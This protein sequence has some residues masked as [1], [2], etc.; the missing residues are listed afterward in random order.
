[1]IAGKLTDGIY[2]KKSIASAKTSPWVAYSMKSPI[3]TFKFNKRRLVRKVMIHVLND[4]KQINIFQRAII[5]MGTQ[6]GNFTAITEYTSNIDQ[7]NNVGTMAVW[8]NLGEI[9]TRHIQIEFVKSSRWLLV[10]EVVFKSDEYPPKRLFP[11]PTVN[12]M[13]ME[14]VYQSVPDG[15]GEKNE[16][17]LIRNHVSNNMGGNYDVVFVLFY[18]FYFLLAKLKNVFLVFWVLKVK[19]S[20]PTES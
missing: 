11:V 6:D 7:L 18:L 16:K 1:M 9:L 14:V 20:C 3:I 10:S 13:A 2:G 19:V 5:R 4:G 15:D 8:I 12:D 17:K